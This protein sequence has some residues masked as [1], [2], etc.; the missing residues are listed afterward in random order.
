MASGQSS[1]RYSIPTSRPKRGTGSER[2]AW[3]TVI[4]TAGNVA[5]VTQ[6]H[7]L[8]HGDEIGA[9]GDAGHQDMEKREENLDK[10]IVWDVAMKRSKRKALT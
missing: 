7:A 5:D 3:H 8:L 9:L 1:A 10:T 2:L 4:G 6:A